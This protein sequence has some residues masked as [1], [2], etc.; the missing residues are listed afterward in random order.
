[1]TSGN[2]QGRGVK[3]K[4]SAMSV[5]IWAPSLGEGGLMNLGV[6]S[7]SSRDSCRHL[8]SKVRSLNVC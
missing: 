2:G 3:P 7:S 6:D 1:M 8:A 5:G 4:L